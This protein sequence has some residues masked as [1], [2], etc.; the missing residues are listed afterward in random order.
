MIFHPSGV[1]RSVVE[2]HRLGAR[3]D[4]AAQHH[5][6]V[7]LSGCSPRIS[8]TLAGVVVHL[9]GVVGDGEVAK[10]LNPARLLVRGQVVPFAADDRAAMKAK[11]KACEI[12]GSSFW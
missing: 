10:G 1:C 5:G 6:G 9:R 2:V 4:D 3:F 7:I 8:N 12:A 11:S